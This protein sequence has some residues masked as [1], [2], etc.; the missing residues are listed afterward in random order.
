V[1]RYV[2]FSADLLQR[3]VQMQ[4]LTARYRDLGEFFD[5]RSSGLVHR[6]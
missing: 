5:M 6:K 1:E 2:S 4:K 3:P